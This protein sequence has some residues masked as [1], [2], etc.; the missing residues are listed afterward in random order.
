MVHPLDLRSSPAARKSPSSILIA[1]MF[2]YGNI[3]DNRSFSRHVPCRPRDV[4][5]L[6]VGCLNEEIAA[7]YGLALQSHILS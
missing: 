4:R 5:K 3:F 6:L 1:A 2:S 7:K